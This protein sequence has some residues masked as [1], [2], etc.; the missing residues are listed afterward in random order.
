MNPRSAILNPQLRVAVIGVGYLGRH[1]ARILGAMPGVDLVGVVDVNRA[2]A[3]EIAAAN[4][5][6]PFLDYRDVVGQV[7][8]VTI[9]V[10]TELHATIGGAFLGAGIAAL[11]EKPLARSVTEADALI[12]AARDG[13]VLAVGHTER[14]N[15]AV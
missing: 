3:E 5:T 4:R 7:D 11:V 9:A 10:P 6:Q 13:A 15:P 1:H 12:S 8:A 14:F 2:R